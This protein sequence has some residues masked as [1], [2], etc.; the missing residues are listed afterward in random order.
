[1]VMVV[2]TVTMTMLVTLKV[3][4]LV[5]MIMMVMKM[6]MLLLTVMA[7]PRGPRGGLRQARLPRA[8]GEAHGRHGG[9]LQVGEVVRFGVLVAHCAMIW[10]VFACL[11]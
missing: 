1:M 11:V 7:G 5:M 8:A 10:E 2:V 6:T 9:G 4:V 3:M